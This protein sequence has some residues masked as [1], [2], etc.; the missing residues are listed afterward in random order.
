[1]IVLSPPPVVPKAIQVPPSAT[2]GRELANEAPPARFPEME[3]KQIR[4]VCDNKATAL[5][6]Q[7]E[8]VEID[9]AAKHGQEGDAGPG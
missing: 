7:V 2:S 3:R 8:V 4:P 6:R 9:I 1:M 5:A